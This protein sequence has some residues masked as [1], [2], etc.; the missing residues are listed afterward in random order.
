MTGQPTPKQGDAARES[1]VRACWSCRGPAPRGDL[2]C[3]TC[4]ALQPPRSLDYFRRLG[5]EQD[6]DVDRAEL[7][8]NYFHYQR[9]LHPD[10][11]ATRTAKER[12]LSQ[13]HATDINDAYQTLGDSLRR[14]EYLLSLLG[15][16]VNA[17]ADTID[18][19]DLLNESMARREALAEADSG[20]AVDAILE[21]AAADSDVCR[22]RLS[23]A[24]ADNDIE[25]AV[26]L[27]VRLKYLLKLVA[28]ARAQ[29]GRL[30]AGIA[31][32]AMTS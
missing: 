10:R 2:F 15:R 19:P 29:R 16:T 6:Y 7:D 5:L 21:Q 3:P 8:R 24:F 30:G 11:F 23:A 25:E 12:A 20:D 4:Q 18:D 28:E 9:L 26:R 17:G 14:A 1:G 31:I 32:A 27:A 22:T 13:Q